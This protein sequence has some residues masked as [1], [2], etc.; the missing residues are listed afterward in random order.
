MF[1]FGSTVLYANGDPSTIREVPP[2]RMAFKYE[3]T[4]D[5]G[6]RAILLRYNNPVQNAPDDI[7]TN[8]P[9]P[10]SVTIEVEVAMA[11]TDVKLHGLNQIIV[12]DCE[13]DMI[14]KY[15]TASFFVLNNGTLYHNV[16]GPIL[17]IDMQMID[18]DFE[19]N[20]LTGYNITTLPY[21]PK[22]D[23]KDEA[24]LEKWWDVKNAEK[25]LQRILVIL[26]LIIISILILLWWMWKNALGPF[27]KP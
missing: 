8:Y 15:N 16:E 12:Y 7:I 24:D 22:F 13:H 4:D 27:K 14:T 1:T 19:P 6:I 18:P 5:D 21:D 23:Q 10:N 25:Q 17:R 11:G 20:P 2:T 26:L 9:C 3:V